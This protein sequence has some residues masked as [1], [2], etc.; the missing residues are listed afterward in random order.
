VVC[1]AGVHVEDIR[2]LSG[3]LL[4]LGDLTRPS[5]TTPASHPYA[6]LFSRDGNSQ[7]WRSILHTAKRLAFT[8][9]HRPDRNPLVVSLQACDVALPQLL[10]YH[11][12]M[13]NNQDVVAVA[14]GVATNPVRTKSKGAD[15]RTNRDLQATLTVSP[16]L[17]C[18]WLQEIELGPSFQYHSTFLCPVTK[19][20]CTDTADSERGAPTLEAEPSLAASLQMLQRQGGMPSSAAAAMLAFPMA[21]VASAGMAVAAAALSSAVGVAAANSSAAATGAFSNPPVLLKCGHCISA[22]AMEKIVRNLRLARKFK[23][24]TCPQEQTHADTLILHL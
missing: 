18:L 20:Q 22:H 14:K 8:H 4:F 24:P 13:K 16:P 12:V 7:L 11:A 1:F 2:R 17:C 10:K 5:S 6:S 23:C 21:A 19:E 9:M 3:C 15:E